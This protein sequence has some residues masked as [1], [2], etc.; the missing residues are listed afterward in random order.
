[1]NGR[2]RKERKKSCVHVPVCVC[3]CLF[4]ARVYFFPEREKL[5]DGV[6]EKGA[7]KLSEE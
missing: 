6:A 4:C 2:I 7:I 5:K 3:V 1:M